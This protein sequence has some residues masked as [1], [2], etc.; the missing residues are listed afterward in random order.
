MRDFL[1]FVGGFAACLWFIWGVL[2]VDRRSS[3]RRER[4]EVMAEYGGA[5]AIPTP[6][7]ARES[8][9]VLAQPQ[10]DE[11]VGELSGAVCSDTAPD[12]QLIQGGRK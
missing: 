3:A 7:Q 1:F 12:L 5:D 10:A 6:E 2:T 8:A 4:R 11:S 9:V